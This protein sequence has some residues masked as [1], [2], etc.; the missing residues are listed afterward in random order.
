MINQE[1]NE[2]NGTIER[3]TAGLSDAHEALIE[4]IEELAADLIASRK[5]VE[6]LYRELYV[7]DRAVSDAHAT[8][9]VLQ[10]QRARLEE[11][12]R[13]LRDESTEL[14]FKKPKLTTKLSTICYF[15]VS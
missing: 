14:Y 9:E 12:E 6:R 15:P 5:L 13:V 8:I 7:S 10:R 1:A 3:L 11:S 4:Q 2:L